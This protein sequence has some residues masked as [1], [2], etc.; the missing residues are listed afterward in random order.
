MGDLLSEGLGTDRFEPELYH[1][2]HNFPNAVQ[3]QWP[4][5]SNAL[6]LQKFKVTETKHGWMQKS[7]RHHDWLTPRVMD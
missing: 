1:R 7:K 4:V 2:V 3:L 5:T 6:N